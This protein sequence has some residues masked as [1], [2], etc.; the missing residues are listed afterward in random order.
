[1]VG[2]LLY[3]KGGRGW[4]LLHN[5][6]PPIQWVKETAWKCHTQHIY[7]LWKTSFHCLLVFTWATY[8]SDSDWLLCLLISILLCL[9]WTYIWNIQ[10]GWSL[11]HCV[12]CCHV[13]TAPHVRSVGCVLALLYTFVGDLECPWLWAVFTLEVFS[14]LNDLRLNQTKCWRIP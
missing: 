14:S 4:R 7:F 13:I 6:I 2:F 10:K 8:A 12:D 5:A 3:M 11:L 9:F 1:M